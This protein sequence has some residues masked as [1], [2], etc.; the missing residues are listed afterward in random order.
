MISAPCAVTPALYFLSIVMAHVAGQE[1]LEKSTPLK[2]KKMNA[3]ETHGN[4]LLGS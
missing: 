1:D 4:V 3:V 2:G